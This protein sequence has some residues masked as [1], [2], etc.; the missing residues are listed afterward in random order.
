MDKKIAVIGV[1][2]IGGSLGGFMSLNG[3]DV[4][5]IDPWRE[6]VDK[7]R[8]GG[9]LLDGSTGEH[10]VEVKALHTDDVSGL[11]ERFDVVIIGVKSYNT[12]WAAELMLPHMK[13]DTWVVSVQ[14]GINEL[15]IAPIVGARRTLGCITTI[16]ANMMEPAHVNRTQSVSQSIQARPVCF[17][18]G[19]LD[20][21]VTPRIKELAEMFQPAG[22]CVV[23]E[24][25]W[26]E[27]WTKLAINCMAN[28]TASMTGATNYSMR[29]DDGSRQLML[30]F[31]V[32]AMKVGRTL[33]YSVASPIANFDLDDMELASKGSYPEF[34]RVF[35]GEPPKN[36]GRPSMA[37][38]PLD[39]DRLPQR[40][41]GS[42]G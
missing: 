7:M 33:G 27:R 21:G 37:Q 29:A 9:L 25:L 10:R 23:T 22:E 8:S 18:V 32:E 4:T 26:A 41:R 3:E 12:R 36:P 38:G 6:S 11:D 16:S 28:P 19:E 20:G 2:A 40:L 15:Q 1:G 30:K 42:R 13:E 17:K 5:L 35:V 34:E 31:G 14:N 39:G 24:D